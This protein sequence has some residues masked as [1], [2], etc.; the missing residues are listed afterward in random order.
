MDKK[1]KNAKEVAYLREINKERIRINEK[2]NNTLTELV[3]KGESLE[4]YEIWTNKKCDIMIQ[5]VFI[6]KKVAKD[7]EKEGFN[8]DTAYAIIKRQP[9]EGEK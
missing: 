8:V 9:E 3:R 1:Q 7:L 4:D 2:L 5:P 6:I